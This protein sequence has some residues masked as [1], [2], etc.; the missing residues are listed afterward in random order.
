MRLR[1]HEGGYGLVTKTLHWLTL[2]ALAAQF[3]IGYVMDDGGGGRGRGR[4]RSGES[5]R[6]RGR[7]GEDDLSLGLGADDDV[8]ITVHVGLGLSIL[9]LALLR[10]LW[11]RATPLPP[12]APGLSARERLVATWTERALYACLL[13]IP[14]SGLLLLLVGDDLLALHV[15]THVLL[16][17]A[18][19]VHVGLILKHQ[20]IMGDRLLHR[21]L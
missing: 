6:G 4:G 10:I 14:A 7:G 8:L 1:N 21:M 2:F 3:V 11:R 13:L 20:L 18:V 15:T 16:F 9:T 19:S 5:G 17:V 12:W